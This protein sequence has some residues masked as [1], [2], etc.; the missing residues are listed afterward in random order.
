MTYFMLLG[1]LNKSYYSKVIN[2]F[3]KKY[4]DEKSSKIL[5]RAD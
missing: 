5:S 3:A 4:S 1:F 2:H